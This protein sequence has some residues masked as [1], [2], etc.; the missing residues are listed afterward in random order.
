M[1]RRREELATPTHSSTSACYSRTGWTPDINQARHL[2][3]VAAEAG[4]TDA[5]LNLALL[6]ATRLEPPEIGEAR[7]WFA[8]AV[9]AG[10]NED[11]HREGV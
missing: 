4:H 3:T 5:Q 11:T 8:A 7:R 10:D 6:L 9:Q 2:Y 1:D